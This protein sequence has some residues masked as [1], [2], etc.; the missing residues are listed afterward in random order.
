MLQTF[1]TDYGG[2]GGGRPTLTFFNVNFSALEALSTMLK[3]R[4]PPPIDTGWI[5]HY[6]PLPR[7]LLDVGLHSSPEQ[8]LG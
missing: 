5:R 8:P 4:P 3:K 1:V 2:G 6:L 7:S